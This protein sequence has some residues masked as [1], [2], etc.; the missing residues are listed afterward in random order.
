V[1]RTVIFR[2]SDFEGPTIERH[3][4]IIDTAGAVWWGWW[5]KQHEPQRLHVL[6]ELE[7]LVET[8]REQ[9]TPLTIG[10]VNRRERKFFRA[11][12]VQ[13]VWDT[14]GERTRTPDLD[15]TPEYYRTSQHP[16]WLKLTQIH[17]LTEES[18]NDEFAAV[19]LPGGDSTLY[20]LEQTSTGDRLQPPF[21]D[22]GS[23]ETTGSAILHLSDCHFGEDHAFGLAAAGAPIEPG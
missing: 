23:E 6:A 9:G 21:P 10:L 15:A 11:E 2:F 12:C 18:W 13:V 1:I 3:Q 16:A 5:R 20:Y 4:Q 7:V 8:R 19:G 22:V 17:A 14:A